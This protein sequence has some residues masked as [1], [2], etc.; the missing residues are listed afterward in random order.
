MSLLKISKF[1]FNIN[2]YKSD[3][4]DSIFISQILMPILQNKN[5][6]YNIFLISKLKNVCFNFFPNCKI[7]KI[8]FSNTKIF[9]IPLFYN[10]QNIPELENFLLKI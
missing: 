7:Y 9:V 4:F 2:S 10:F 3:L 5:L 8:T 1:I 6:N